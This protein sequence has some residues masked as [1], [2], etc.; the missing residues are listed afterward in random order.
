[1]RTYVV[2]DGRANPIDGTDDA[3]VLVT[4]DSL[5][6]ARDYIKDSGWGECYIWSYIDDFHS[7]ED[8]TFVE[9]GEG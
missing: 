1:M 8:E 3:T 9:R 6:E 4:A 5:Q 7:L 2:Y